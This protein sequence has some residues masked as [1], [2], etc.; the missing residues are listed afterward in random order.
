[1]LRPCWNCHRE[2]WES[3][4]RLAKGNRWRRLALAR[5][6]WERRFPL[7]VTYEVD[8]GEGPGDCY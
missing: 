5:V 4:E 6:H 8:R 7:G 2:Y 1:M 3:L